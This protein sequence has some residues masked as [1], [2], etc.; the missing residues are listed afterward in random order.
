MTCGREVTTSRRVVSIA[1]RVPNGI[2]LVPTRDVSQGAPT[3]KLAWPIFEIDLT[4]TVGWKKWLKMGRKVGEFDSRSFG[5]FDLTIHL[6]QQDDANLID[7]QK[8]TV[9]FDTEKA[10]PLLL[11]CRNWSTTRDNQPFQTAHFTQNPGEL[12][13]IATWLR[14]PVAGYVPESWVPHGLRRPHRVYL[15]HRRL[16]CDLVSTSVV[17]KSIASPALPYSILSLPC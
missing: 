5:C 4:G 16:A 7:Q 10:A 2:G 1:R 17:E 6:Y 8:M 12:T 9:H 15:P 11:V 13:A 14:Q 3:G